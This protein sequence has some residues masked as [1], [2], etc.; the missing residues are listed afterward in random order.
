[1]N[2]LTP[3][4]GTNYN[5]GPLTYAQAAT[6]Y[7]TP[8]NIEKAVNMGKK[9]RQ[10][11]SS[12]QKPTNRRKRQRTEKRG[13]AQRGTVNKLE[14]G[15][16]S[17]FDSKTLY[18]K[19]KPNRRAAARRRSTK[20]LAKKI[21]RVS[22]PSHTLLNGIVS[23]SVVV[24][25]EEYYCQQWKAIPIFDPDDLQKVCKHAAA[26]SGGNK[27]PETT[28]AIVQDEVDRL[29]TTRVYMRHVSWEI[30][31]IQQSEP[32]TNNTPMILDIYYMQSRRRLN[33]DDYSSISGLLQSDTS[34]KAG[35]TTTTDGDTIGTDPETYFAR[36]YIS[37]YEHRELS[38]YFEC[39][40]K[41]QVQMNTGSVITLSGLYQINKNLGVNNWDNLIGD[42][43]NT[44]IILLS[45]RSADFNND[46]DGVKGA[47][48]LRLTKVF[49][50]KV[51][52]IRNNPSMTT[53]TYTAV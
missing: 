5:N 23:T 1:M 34:G 16:T 11:T 32:M 18:V 12:K 3:Y 33:I 35:V 36:G 27:N 40:K 44:E 9:F 31:M 53:N 49:R 43:G 22:L 47:V 13:N 14:G 30:T 38:K 7:L 29:H 37:P 21:A 46:G 4:T 39:Y 10:W 41:K 48:Q 50:Y 19:R 26:I 24:Q 15:V 8:Q 25:D 6:Q 2:Q 45:L 42:K 28:N 17:H 20:R 51:D 52:P